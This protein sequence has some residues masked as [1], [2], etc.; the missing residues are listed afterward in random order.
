MMSFTSLLL[1]ALDQVYSI[2]FIKWA[3]QI[4][5]LQILNQVFNQK[6]LKG[7]KL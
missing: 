4:L 6:I 3:K 1:I 2:F 7:K 5:Q